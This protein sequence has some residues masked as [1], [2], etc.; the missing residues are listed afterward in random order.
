MDNLLLVG[1]LQS[2]GDLNDDVQRFGNRHGTLSLDP[3][4]N[5]FPLDIFHR[6]VTVLSGLSG[7]EDL[8]DRRMLEL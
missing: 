2:V 4:P 8:N 6:D 1:G 5:R 3:L 7:V